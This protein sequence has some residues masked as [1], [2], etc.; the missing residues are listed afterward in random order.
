MLD[1][2]EAIVVKEIHNYFMPRNI[3]L[4]LIESS[5]SHKD[6][7]SMKWIDSH[8]ILKG[9]NLTLAS[10]EMTVWS[11]EDKNIEMGW[12]RTDG[13]TYGVKVNHVKSYASFMVESCETRSKIRVDEVSFKLDID[14]HV[15]YVQS[16][17]VCEILFELLEDDGLMSCV[18]FIK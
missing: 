17:H 9:V 11:K 13:F 12:E 16:G 4:V 6:L 5:M 8:G 1:N 2:I 10:M 7:L 14:C 3:T 18:K 15:D